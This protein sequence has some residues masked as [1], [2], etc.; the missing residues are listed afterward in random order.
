MLYLIWALLLVGLA[1]PFF[2]VVNFM[3]FLMYW[4]S[5]KYF[6]GPSAESDSPSV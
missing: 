1:R 4:E 5:A 2:H 6:S 3:V